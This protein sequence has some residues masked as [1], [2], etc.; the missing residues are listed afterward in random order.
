MQLHSVGRNNAERIFRRS[1]K[2]GHASSA[3]ATMLT[4]LLATGTERQCKVL[5][6]LPPARPCYATATPHHP[7]QLFLLYCSSQQCFFP[8][9]H[10]PA[11]PLIVPQCNCFSYCCHL[12]TLLHRRC[13][14]SVGLLPFSCSCCCQESLK[15]YWKILG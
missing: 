5:L 11:A 8:I 3:P 10:Y 9:P 6:F 12:C 15:H 2:P 13:L 1:G 7:V 4:L 14:E